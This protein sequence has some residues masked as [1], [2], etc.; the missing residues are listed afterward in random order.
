MSGISTEVAPSPQGLQWFTTKPL[1]YL[2]YPPNRAWRLDKDGGHL[3]GRSGHSGHIVE[4]FRSGG[5]VA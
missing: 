3:A 1:E 4:K 5:H 2:V